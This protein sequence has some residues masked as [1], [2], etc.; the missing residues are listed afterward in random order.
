VEVHGL[1]RG[2]GGLD[3]PTQFVVEV[4][5]VDHLRLVEGPRHRGFLP[6]VDEVE[7]V[8]DLQLDRDQLFSKPLAP[9]AGGLALEDEEVEGQPATLPLLAQQGHPVN[10]HEVP[11]VPGA[12][13][14]GEPPPGVDG[15]HHGRALPVLVPRDAL[16]P[17]LADGRSS[18]PVVTELAAL[19]VGHVEQDLLVDV[20]LS[21]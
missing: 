3:E 14:R 13:L 1:R 11:A 17:G 20:L 8:V 10:D 18:I 4:V 9:Y 6:V 21:A 16:G 5:G 7:D 15:D 12:P 2:A 19:A